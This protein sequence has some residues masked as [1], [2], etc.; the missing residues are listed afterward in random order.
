MAVAKKA[1][2]KATKT[3]SVEEREAMQAAADEAKRKKSGK[4]DGEADIRTAIAKMD[5]ADRKMAERIH[6][7]QRWAFPMRQ[8]STT[9]ICGPTLMR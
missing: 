3:F 4:A 9:A 5:A 1:A 7:T 6:A 2:T 8:S